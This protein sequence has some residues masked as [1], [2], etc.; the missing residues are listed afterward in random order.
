MFSF[1]STELRQSHQ[2]QFDK[3]TASFYFRPEYAV[4]DIW[5]LWT[6]LGGFV[7]ERDSPLI[8]TVAVRILFLSSL[9]VTKVVFVVACA[10]R[11]MA[12][13]LDS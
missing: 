1:L 9:F 2:C 12:C 5:F 8:A 6:A 10:T 11:L 7:A 13:D 4:R 3:I